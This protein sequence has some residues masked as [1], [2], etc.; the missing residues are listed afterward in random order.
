M[1]IHALWE[2][3]YGISLR[4]GPLDL[5]DQTASSSGASA[6]TDACSHTNAGAVTNNTDSNSKQR[7]GKA[8]FYG[9]GS[10]LGQGQNLV[11]ATIGQRIAAGTGANSFCYGLAVTGNP[12]FSTGQE[13]IEFQ[14]GFAAVLH[15]FGFSFTE[16]KPEEVPKEVVSL[17]DLRWE[18]KS[19]KNWA[20]ADRLRDEIKKSGWLIKDT[21]DSY[22]LEKVS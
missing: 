7:G 9:G 3:R 19:S 5:S 21:K 17:A 18:A 1:A 14:S 4:K 13:M 8:H 22:E 20:E 15:L 12:D 11:G 16:R 10:D 6:T 2:D